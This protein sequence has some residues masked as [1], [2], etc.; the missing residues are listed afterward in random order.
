ME[1]FY[2][3]GL[4][5]NCTQCSK[6]CRHEPGYVF[7]SYQDIQR[8]ADTLEISPG[9]VVEEYCILVDLGPVTRISLKE[10]SNNDCLFWRNGCVIYK[11]RPLQCRSYPFWPAHIASEESWNELEQEC[12]GVNRG[13]IHSYEEIEAWEALR[14]EEPLIDAKE[15]M[16]EVLGDTNE[17]T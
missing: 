7:L 13:K 17:N 10:T 12:P 14:R 4:K 5:F 8:I 15:L 11:G 1:K 3:A 6:C 2:K 16:D 9:K